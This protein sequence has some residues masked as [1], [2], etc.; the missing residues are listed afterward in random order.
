MTIVD[1][2]NLT[3]Y[4]TYALE[5]INEIYPRPAEASIAPITLP[6]EKREDVYTLQ[7]TRLNT[8]PTKGIYITNGRKQLR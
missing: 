5:G 6:S 7:G 4:G 1:R 2:K 8:P 3:V